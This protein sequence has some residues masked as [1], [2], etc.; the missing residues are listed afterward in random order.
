M[1][2]VLPPMDTTW[3]LYGPQPCSQYPGIE[4]A[5][6]QVQTG[7]DDSCQQWGTL[8]AR[9]APKMSA[10]GIHLCLNVKT[11]QRQQGAPAE[12]E[13]ES[14]TQP[15]VLRRRVKVTLPQGGISGGG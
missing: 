2:P 4:C 14:T 9:V 1:Q 13:H 7:T 11:S 5:G 10:C 15:P 12:K 6:T 3:L 8:A